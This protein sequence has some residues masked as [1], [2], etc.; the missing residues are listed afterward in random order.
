MKLRLHPAARA[1][2]LEAIERYEQQVPGLGAQFLREVENASARLLAQPRSAP[3]VR[4]EFRR[5][6][7]RQFPYGIIYR[8]VADE[9]R[10]TAIAHRRR[11]P[12]YWVRRTDP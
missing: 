8:I 4:G 10:V 11:R 12:G 7:L 6:G 9:L 1:E 3:L 2:F 5:L